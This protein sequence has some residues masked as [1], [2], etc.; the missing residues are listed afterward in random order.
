MKGSRQKNNLKFKKHREDSIPNSYIK[1]GV[2][3]KTNLT[4]EDGLEDGEAEENLSQNTKITERLF[5]SKGNS[6]ENVIENLMVKRADDC[7]RLSK[8][9]PA[10]DDDSSC[11]DA[12]FVKIP[13]TEYISKEYKKQRNR[14]KN[15]DI[16]KTIPRGQV[17]RRKMCE[18]LN[19]GIL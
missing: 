8:D 14:I 13:I 2:S 19:D 12:D 6:L 1:Q 17:I 16:C 5:E 4:H 15:L 7:Q 10:I 3:E 18:K 11:D 9:F